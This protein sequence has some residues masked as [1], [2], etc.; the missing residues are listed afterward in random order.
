MNCANIV[1]RLRASLSLVHYI[2]GVYA[3]SI[4]SVVATKDAGVIGEGIN[5][6]SVSRN[7]GKKGK[8]GIVCAAPAISSSVMAVFQSDAAG[9]SYL[10]DCVSGLRS[11]IISKLHAT[12]KTISD[13]SI[14]ITALL[15]MARTETESQRMTKDAIGTWFDADLADLICCAIRNK[16]GAIADDKLGKL[17]E[18]YKVKFQSL[19]SREINMPL[20]VK[21]QLG[22]ALEL[23][24]SDY[25]SIIGEKVAQ[26]LTDAEEASETLAAL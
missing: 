7:D 2:I 11:K 4:Y 17:V 20:A 12:G 10:I 6:Y 13:E 9:V 8:S 15:A 14:G 21:T 19:A 5:L 22:K 25:E 26:A 23:L 24:P 18:S 16:I 1:V 3:M